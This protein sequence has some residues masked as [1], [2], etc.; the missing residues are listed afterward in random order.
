MSTNRHLV[1]IVVVG[2][3]MAGSRLVEDLLARASRD[4]APAL[5]I[6]V[7]GAEPYPAYNRV[8]LSEVVAGRA[9]IAS[10]A[11]ADVPD[12][13]ED[14]S[15]QYAELCMLLPPCWPTEPS[16]LDDL[17]AWPFDTLVDCARLP[18]RNKTWL[19]RGHTVYDGSPWP[20]TLLSSMMLTPPYSFDNASWVIDGEPPIHV[21]QLVPITADELAFKKERG[22]SALEDELVDYDVRIFGALEPQRRCSVAGKNLFDDTPLIAPPKSPLP[23]GGW[24]VVPAR[25][26]KTS[27]ALDRLLDIAASTHEATELRIRHATCG[28]GTNF[29]LVFGMELVVLAKTLSLVDNRT[30]ALRLHGE[31]GAARLFHDGN[32]IQFVRGSRRE[33]LEQVAEHVGSTSDDL[34]SVAGATPETRVVRWDRKGK[35]DPS[36]PNIAWNVLVDR[37]LEIEIVADLL[38]LNAAAIIDRFGFWRRALDRYEG[39]ENQHETMQDEDTRQELREATIVA[40][41]AHTDMLGLLRRLDSSATDILFTALERVLDDGGVPIEYMVPFRTW[42][43]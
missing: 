9:D 33:L 35:P 42:A 20:G 31:H 38:A 25:R 30:A 11:T 14:K 21:F 8:L 1:R 7:V 22:S 40:R 17:T 37:D 24:L 43:S 10:L 13:V 36:N 12:G 3:G 4:G 41:Q 28:D 29:L 23:E 16:N 39:A 27:A 2:F 15:L 18:H 34:L 5:S 19:W 32:E 6:T 26:A